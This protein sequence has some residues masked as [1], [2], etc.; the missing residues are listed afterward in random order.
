V[1][2]PPFVPLRPEQIALVAQNPVPVL[3]LDGH[4]RV[5]Y[6]N[7]SGRALSEDPSFDPTGLVVWTQ[8]PGLAGSGLQREYQRV[9]R[10]RVPAR[11]EEYRPEVDRW[12]AVLAYPVEDGLI[13]TL[14]DITQE[15]RNADAVRRS[16]Q[17]LRL[18]QESARIGTFSRDLRLNQSEWSD[19]L[20]RLL[21]MEP[22]AIDP[23]VADQDPDQG[24]VHADDRARLRATWKRALISGRTEQLRHR[25]VRRD[26]EERLFDSHIFTV[27]DQHDEAERV[28]GTVRDVTDEVRADAERAQIA[29]QM[30]QAQKLESLGILAGGIAHDFNNLL[31]GILGNASLALLDLSND[32]PVRDSVLEIERA[33]QRAAELTRQLLAYAGKG[34]F[35]VELVDCSQV[36]REM[37]ALLRTAVSRNAQ[38]SLQLEEALPAIEV[39]V[40]QLRQVVMNLITNASDALPE[41]GGLVVLRTGEQ[42]IDAA[43][44]DSCVPGTEA[45]PGRHVFIEVSDEGAGMDA[46]TCARMFDPFFTTKFTGRGLGLA[47]T[48]GI[49]RG[50]HGAIRVHSEPGQGT[51]IRL[52]FPARQQPTAP[53]A[54]LPASRA[55]H[56]D[57]DVLVVDDEPSVRA[58]T[59]ALLRRRGFA[60]TEA[61]SGGEAVEMV[62]A[63][64]ARFRLVL[65]DLTMPGMSGEQTFRELR[66]LVPGLTV[67]LM[68]GYNEQEVTRLFANHDWAAFLQKPFRAEDLD[69]TV[70]GVLGT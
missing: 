17:T 69:G 12:F 28:V 65:L 21:A 42:A 18:A 29:A 25:V 35:V 2:L 68:S 58:V 47:A 41:A 33:A 59:R 14:R 24:F 15:K 32:S 11:F 19:Q 22:G 53:L 52:H 34:R 37:T 62:R 44:L 13:A 1:T 31:V 20:F 63:H 64:P 66:Q 5:R 48:L 36:V 56:G 23:N 38:V 61:A 49:V 57:G 8:Y 7:P 55:W 43:Y 46:D 4:E 67:I 10:D 30:Q 70:Q 39:D 60:V 26:G 6:V 40:T 16:E 54:T 3:V 45:S 27:R 51:S 9:L 50:H